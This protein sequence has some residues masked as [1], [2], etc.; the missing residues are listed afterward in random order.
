MVFKCPNCCRVV[1]KEDVERDQGFVTCQNC[2]NSF[3]L[4]IGED[5]YEK[6]KKFK[7]AVALP[8]GI[9]LEKDKTILTV[10]ISFKKTIFPLYAFLFV[11]LIY[12]NLPSIFTNST[13]SLVLEIGVGIILSYTALAATFNKTTLKVTTKSIDIKHS[14]IPWPTQKNIMSKDID[15]IFCKMKSFRRHLTNYYSYGVFVKPIMGNPISLLEN[16]KTSDQGLYIVQEI[17]KI[18]SIED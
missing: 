8:D 13:L 7:D 14:P 10:I 1:P 4:S 17:E 9:K 6:K 2:S 18:L 5:T 15:Q 16:L 3:D 11:M 12:H